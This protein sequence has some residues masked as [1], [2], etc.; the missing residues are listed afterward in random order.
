M[1]QDDA[2]P[3][4]GAADRGDLGRDPLP[5]HG[6]HHAATARTLEPIRKEMQMVFQDPQASLN[7]RKR[8]G[9]ILATPLSLRGVA[10]NKVTEREPRA[11]GA[12]RDVERRARPLSPRVLR[13]PAP[14]DRDRPRAGDESEADPARRAGLGA[15]RLDPGAGDQP[16]RRPPGRAGPQLR[17]RRPRPQRRP[18]RVGPDRRHVPGQADGDLARRGAVLQADP[19]VH[20]G[21][22]RARSRSRTPS[23]IASASGSSSPA[24]RPTR[25][26]RRPAAAFTPGARARPRCAARSSRS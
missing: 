8:I 11:A 5:R 7:P 20:H 16:A 14:A 23:R 15:G 13:R 26:T 22:A 6:H 25:S 10:K 3:R 2:D 19:S 1:W 24:S 9:Q 12:G 4:A 18:A 21:A 17:V